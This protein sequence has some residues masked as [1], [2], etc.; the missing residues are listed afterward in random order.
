M[1]QEREEETN[2]VKKTLGDVRQMLESHTTPY[3]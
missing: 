2:G 1:Q 3:Q